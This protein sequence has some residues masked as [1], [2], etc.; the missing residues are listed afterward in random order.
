MLPDDK[1]TT[2]QLG[3][4]RIDAQTIPHNAIS[5]CALVEATF[6]NTAK[7]CIFSSDMFTLYIDPTSRKAELVRFPKGTL[8]ALREQ[9]L[10]PGFE[11]RGDKLHLGKC[12]LPTFAAFDPNGDVLAIFLFFID[13]NVPHPE[14]GKYET[15]YPMEAE[16]HH[17]NPIRNST[18][19]AAVIPY[20]FNE[21]RF[22]HQMWTYVILPKT[23]TR[24]LSLM[25]MH[26]EGP[27][28]KIRTPTPSPDLLN[29]Q[30]SRVNS[31]NLSGSSSCS[32]PEVA[33]HAP[34]AQPYDINEELRKK[35][36]ADPSWC[37]HLRNPVH[38]FD[39]DNPNI[40]AIMSSEKMAK[41]EL[42][43]IS[44]ICAA[45]KFIKLRL[46]A[47]RVAGTQGRHSHRS[48][49]LSRSQRA[50]TNFP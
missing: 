44:E 14:D 26:L 3:Q 4:G 20:D 37:S 8:A 16:G 6:N 39:G 41:Y 13:R 25:R 27:L 29:L 48:Q 31:A 5:C 46:S 28:K 7:E 18:L 21:D 19:F 47:Y 34:R 15:I 9:K 11:E 40:N 10:S 36:L 35:M 23:E 49:P 24:C 32:V 22:M 12:A 38:C 2:K 43:S 30:S 1:W 45:K 50:R 33:G 17:S 42:K